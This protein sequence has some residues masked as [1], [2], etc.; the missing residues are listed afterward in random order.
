MPWC[1]HTVRNVYKTKSGYMNTCAG[2]TVGAGGRTPSPN[3]YPYLFF[4]LSFTLNDPKAERHAVS[5]E[6]T[7]KA[8]AETITI[9]EDP[10]FENKPQ[11]ASV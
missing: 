3:V 6:G 11:H 9:I 5:K 1:T 8:A 10:S 2:W 7:R 4:C